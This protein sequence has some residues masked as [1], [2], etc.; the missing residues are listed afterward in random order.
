MSDKTPP[1]D[2]T[3]SKAPSFPRILLADDEISIVTH[4][5]RVLR[6][7]G[8]KVFVASDGKKALQIFRS[9]PIDLVL[10][11]VKMPEL[12]GVQLLKAI[13]EVNSRT[14]VILISGYH[15]VKT[16][17]EALKA[18]A[19]NFLT[20][21]LNI[22]DLTS[23]INR[24]LSLTHIKMVANEHLAAL[25]QH[26][27]MEIPSNYQW[28]TEAVNQIALSAVGVGYVEFDLHNNVK[29]ALIEGLTNAME[30]GNKWDLD[31]VVKVEVQT[32]KE[33]LQ[34]TITDQG[35]GFDQ[36]SLTDPTD[37]ENMLNERGRGVF[38]MQAIMDEVKY[39]PPGNRLTLR[40]RKQPA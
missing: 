4:L 2:N 7:K 18:G 16:V 14:P 33:L 32:S 3:E 29:L 26:T 15:D 25:K 31:K 40:R 37:P 13:K 8:Y 39:D 36:T 30:H 5:T 12:N 35:Q 27:T 1:S 9:E 10:S 38:L 21:P 20:K 28:I 24:S 11:D 34:V 19:E 6:A 17:V 22:A 23:V